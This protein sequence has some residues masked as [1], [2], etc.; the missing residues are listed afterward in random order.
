MEGNEAKEERHSLPW[1]GLKAS[2][3]FT[4]GKVD[5]PSMHVHALDGTANTGA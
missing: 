5:R 2:N 1:Q 4:G 3:F